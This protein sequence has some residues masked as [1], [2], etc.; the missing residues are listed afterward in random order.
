MSEE[1]PSTELPQTVPSQETIPDETPPTKVKKP[2]TPAQL[3]AFKRAQATRMKNIERAKQEKPR[4]KHR[5]V[6]ELP[7]EEEEEEE[8]DTE[9]LVS[10]DDLA[11]RLTERLVKKW[12]KAKGPEP[13]PARAPPPPEP[14]QRPVTQQNPSLK[15]ISI[16]TRMKLELAEPPRFQSQKL[17]VPKGWPQPVGLVGAFIGM[18]GSGKTSRQQGAV[19]FRLYL[20]ADLGEQSGALWSGQPMD[21]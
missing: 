20:L 5:K 15:K 7:Q 12:P 6:V 9:M 17:D 8:E 2:R 10:L 19:E 18:R 4:G 13:P 3:E 11:D 1:S 21:H 16:E 14:P